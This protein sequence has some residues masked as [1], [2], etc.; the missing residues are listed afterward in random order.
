MSLRTLRALWACAVLGLVPVLGLQAQ[1]AAPQAASDSA[2]LAAQPATPIP[3]QPPPTSAGSGTPDEQLAQDERNARYLMDLQ[4]ANQTRNVQS[5]EVVRENQEKASAA[6]LEYYRRLLEPQ[7]QAPGTYQTGQLQPSGDPFLA[8]PNAAKAMAALQAS[9]GTAAPGFQ[10]NG[11]P[12]VQATLP[13]AVQPGGSP[14]D[15]EAGQDGPTIARR[16]HL[17]FLP[18]GSIVDIRLLTRVNTSIPGPVIGE[19]VFDVWDVDQRYIL[20]P[21]GSKAIG[22]SG[23]MGSDTDSGGKVV[24]DTF[25]DP[26]GREI[27]IAIP[28]VT[29]SRVGV[30]GVPGKIDY[31]WG[32]VFGASAALAVIT[33]ITGNT[34][35]PAA[36]NL[37]YSQADAMRQNLMSQ[38]GAL[39]S[40]LL[41]RF[42]QTKPDVTLV[43]GTTSKVIILQHMM[44]R[45]YQKVF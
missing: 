3:Q 16:K 22:S 12:V 38:G 10:P 18:K 17:G 39:G 30:T 4:I 7:D 42:I 25:V 45:P 36:G 9:T 31:H 14:A 11:Q 21:R 41:N 24:F 34:S 5:Q 6:L 40:S 26:S 29:A 13:Q 35:Q 23:Q 19:V 27:P 2:Y 1:Q 32:R 15:A 33:G 44:V 8:N 20:I 37:N 28:V 43:E